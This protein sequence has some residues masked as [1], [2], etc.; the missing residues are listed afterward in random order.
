MLCVY[1]LHAHFPIAPYRLC[2]LS[3]LVG[4][5]AATPML[6]W[7]IKVWQHAA[8][9]LNSCINNILI[10]V[11]AGPHHNCLWSYPVHK[12]LFPPVS[13]IRESSTV[14]ATAGSS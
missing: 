8:V 7:D 3:H 11:L 9:N 13:A 2:W 10:L 5:A 14:Y 4:S 6:W 1:C 12:R